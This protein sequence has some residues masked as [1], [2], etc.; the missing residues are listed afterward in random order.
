MS[1]VGDVLGH[2]V[3]GGVAVHLVAAR[4]EERVLLVRARRRDVRRLHDPDAHALVPAGVDVARVAQRHLVVGGVDRADVHVVE[5]ALAAHEHFIEGPVAH[6]APSCRR[7][8]ATAASRTHAP[9]SWAAFRQAMRSALQGPSPLMTRMSS[10]QSGVPKSYE[11][12]SS[13]HASSG[14]GTVTPRASA[15]G[16]VMSTN[17]CRSSSLV[18]RL[19]PHVIDCSVLGE[20]SSGG[21]NIISDGH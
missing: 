12:R 6:A 21:P 9:S 14:S 10:S 1:H 2:V 15:C 13:F 20:R 7:A 16:T 5:P 11:P 3:E 17:R 8:Y 4:R 19:M 18:C